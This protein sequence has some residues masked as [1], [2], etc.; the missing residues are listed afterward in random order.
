MEKKA[1]TKNVTPEKSRE[2]LR[3]IWQ[4]EKD[5]LVEVIPLLKDIKIEYPTDV[6]YFDVIPVTPPSM[7]PVSFFAFLFSTRYLLIFFNRWP[8]L[9]T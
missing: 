1:N 7:R 2:Y 5:L 3:K 4:V 9:V 6:F 8:L